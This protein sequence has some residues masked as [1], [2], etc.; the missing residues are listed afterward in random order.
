MINANQQRLDKLGMQLSTG[1]RILSPSH[2]AMGA[3]AWM[4]HQAILRR[5]D[6]FQHNANALQQ[7]HDYADAQLGQAADILMQLKTIA[8]RE[9]NAGADAGTRAAAAAE[10]NSLRGALFELA[11]SSFAGLNL[12]GGRK[13][14]GPAYEMLG[15]AVRML[16]TNEVNQV[17]IGHGVKA[18]QGL[19]PAGV[20]GVGG[21]VVPGRVDLNPLSTL[22]LGGPPGAAARSTPLAVLNDGRGVDLGGPILIEIRPDPAL[23]NTQVFAVDVRGAE[24]LTDV[25]AAINSFTQDGELL[26]EA[27]LMPTAGGEYP[28]TAGSALTVRLRDG[29]ALDDALLPGATIRVADQ[30]GRT[31]ARDLGL[32]TASVAH[33]FESGPLEGPF[34]GP[35][36]FSLRVNGRELDLSVTPAGPAGHTELA[37]AMEQAI[38]DELAAEGIAG[39]SVGVSVVD[40]RLR[41]DVQDSTG[42]GYVALEAQ[43]T[44]AALL[45][46]E[47]SRTVSGPTRV[48][49][50]VELSDSRAIYGRDLSPALHGATLLSDLLGGQGLRLEEDPLG[51]PRLPQ[52][53]RV[54]HGEFSAVVNLEPLVND[55][56]ATVADLQQAFKRA[57]VHVE[58]RIS[59]DGRGLEL[60]GQLS[61]ARL[62]VDDFNGTLGT[63]LG[64]TAAGHDT[65]V[66]DLLGGL[67]VERVTGHD[68]ALT[69]RDGRELRFDLGHGDTA[70]SL[71]AAINAAPDNL[72]PGGDPPAWVRA[73]VLRQREF[74]SLP[75]PD[76][77]DAL[78]LTVS[79]NGTEPRAITLPADPGRDADALAAE[80]EAELNQTARLAGLEGF[81][82]RISAEDGELA[83]TVEDTAG[84]ARVAFGGSGAGV[85]GLGGQ[86]DANFE[87]RL[88]GE[89]VSDRLVISD[90]TFEPAAWTEGDAV[91]Q[92]GALNGSGAVDQL[93]LGG[94]FDPATGRFVSADLALGGRGDDGVFG[95]LTD[96]VTAL[97]SG[98]AEAV[99][100]QIDRVQASL[101]TMLDA[102]A[103]AGALAGR[104]QQAV[105][106]IDHENFH[107]KAMSAQ[108][109]DVDL[110]QAAHDFQKLQLVLHAGLSAS[111]SIGQM[112]L[113]QYI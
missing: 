34:A 53:V 112:S 66:D 88:R 37:A 51:A 71:A 87:T 91:P 94:G 69:L 89:T 8:L 32:T 107:V 56:S 40:D 46:L 96:L 99:G 44:A 108:T 113:F 27:A 111:A 57:G 21:N 55:P 97:Q 62:K 41:F 45:G 93:G 109:M 30:P 103:E 92:L 75:V 14:S 3:A 72:N 80:L 58:L 29:T 106:R 39:V 22:A 35:L 49:G 82:S 13:L 43:N 59:A 70:A 85:L 9:S 78:T 102:R 95:V 105:N 7:R 42:G 12:F 36:D 63:Q 60:A 24:T 65:R 83:F 31:T 5:N 90:N 73:E 33:S 2:D 52:G 101:D 86:L 50:A 77:A 38:A 19:N 100:R 11:N 4:N 28:L 48:A 64:I 61:G 23:G 15:N 1:R 54:T 68:M 10:V 16:G 6:A 104:A 67:G 20:F 18:A 47:H 76:P 17:Q 110:A 26:F 98:S 25:V 79:L 74:R 84:V 81:R